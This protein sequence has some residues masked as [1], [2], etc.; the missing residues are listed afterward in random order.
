MK[1]II[2]CLLVAVMLSACG[3]ENKKSES[4][5]EGEKRVGDIIMVNG[6]LGVVFAAT[7]DGR[8]GKAMSVSRTE[9]NW[10]NAKTWCANYGMGWRLPTKDELLVIS[11]NYDVINSALE[12]NGYRGL[13]AY[14]WSSEISDEFCAWSVNVVGGHAV[15]YD[16]N[17][18]YYVRAVSAF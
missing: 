7:T 12:T 6:E 3:G 16:K 17:R 10:N 9:C 1:K 14:Y 8:Q 4:R 11:R 18:D 2:C 15:D 13:G 5:K